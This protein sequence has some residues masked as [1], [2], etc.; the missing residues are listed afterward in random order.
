MNDSVLHAISLIS[1]LYFISCVFFYKLTF[2]AL[3]RKRVLS[4][5][6]LIR[7]YLGYSGIPVLDIELHS[8]GWKVLTASKLYFV[9]IVLC[10]SSCDVHICITKI[11]FDKNLKLCIN[12]IT[13]SLPWACIWKLPEPTTWQWYYTRLCDCEKVPSRNR[14]VVTNSSHYGEVKRNINKTLVYAAN[15]CVR[16]ISSKA[17][18]T[19]LVF[20]QV[21]NESNEW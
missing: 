21:G 13:F 18:P 9:Y 16:N 6:V 8:V 10:E 15:V 20:P 1:W 4:F 17:N 11:P 5:Y 7:T 19:S 14:Y 2:F 12:S 3:Y